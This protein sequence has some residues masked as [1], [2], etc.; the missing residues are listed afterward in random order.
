MDLSNCFDAQNPF[1]ENLSNYR[2]PAV[3]EPV[4]IAAAKGVCA[5]H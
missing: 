5:G 1:G 3:C 4:G 2:R